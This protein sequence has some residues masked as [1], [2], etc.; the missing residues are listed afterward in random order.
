M[1]EAK[2]VFDYLK[3]KEEIEDENIEMR[4]CR[5][6]IEVQRGA[7]SRQF[8]TVEGATGYVFGLLDLQHN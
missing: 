4:V 3:L 6:C 1:K 8:E 5:D 2:I 7:S